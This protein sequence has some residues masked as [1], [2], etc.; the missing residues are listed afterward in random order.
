M[1][2]GMDQSE[3]SSMDNISNSL[4]DEM[5]VDDV[6]TVP[7]DDEIYK[8]F[9]TSPSVTRRYYEDSTLSPLLQLPQP[10]K[11]L[12]LHFVLRMFEQPAGQK[13]ATI[14]ALGRRRLQQEGLPEGEG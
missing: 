5:E 10:H 9:P 2:N 1:E 14:A 12:F 8:E 4:D 11:F 3:G 13:E 6:Q 7:E